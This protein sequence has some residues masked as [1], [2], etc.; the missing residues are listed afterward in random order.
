VVSNALRTCR[1][2]DRLA[3]PARC[4]PADPR[5]WAV[6]HETFST[7]GPLRLD[8]RLP[9][10][11]ISLESH[12]ESATRVELDA[13]R[14][15]EELREVIDSARV[16][17]R[18]HR[19]GH[20]IVVDVHRKRFK[21]FDFMGGEIILRVWAPRGADVAITTASADT[22]ARG[23]WGGLKVATASGDAR[24][25]ELTGDVDI[26]TAS[27]DIELN[28]VGGRVSVNSAS[29]DVGIGEV[30]G[31]VTVRSASGDVEIG[32]AHSSVTVQT[33]SGDQNVR[34]VM[35]GRVTMQSASGDQTVGV[36]RGS[37]VFLDVKTMSGDA[38]SELDVADG[39]AGGDGPEVEV[40]ATAMSGDIRVVRA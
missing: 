35:S 5:G 25:D 29:G 34:S 31:E 24:F 4:A 20:E 8:L 10:G 32:E 13:T 39:P 26:K 7:P 16:E 40:R 22:D 17:L 30:S 27:G 9:S 1:G 18:P 37:R 14:D 38:S 3:P 36:A 33:A 19:D 15:S 21:L 2:E 11:T 23:T 28:R 6:R 12:E